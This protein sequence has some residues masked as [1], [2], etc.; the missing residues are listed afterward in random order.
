MLSP[1][2]LAWADILLNLAGAAQTFRLLRRFPNTPGWRVLFVI[3][4][5]MLCAKGLGL[6]EFHAQGAALRLGPQI[7]SI[8]ISAL[9]LLGVWLAGRKEAA[10]EASEI[11]ARRFI[12]RQ[13]SDRYRLLFEAIQE[14]LFVLDDGGRILEVNAVGASLFGLPPEELAG[15]PFSGF[16]AESASWADPF[17]RAA[18]AGTKPVEA[19]VHSVGDGVRVVE[20][21]ARTFEIGE[22][23]AAVLS[24]RDVTQ[25][26]AL[27]SALEEALARERAR[28]MELDA[29]MDAAPAAIW[30]A[31]DPQ[32][33]VI[34][35]NKA[36]QEFLSL[37]PDVNPS[38]TP[39]GPGRDGGPAHFQ[40]YQDGRPLS[41]DEMPMQVA[42]REGQDLRGVEIEIV[43]DDG[44]SRVVEGNVAPLLDDAG[45]SRGAVSVFFD[46][47]KRKEM[48]R[49]LLAAKEAAETA[50]RAKGDFLAR[51]S[52]E[53]RSP[54]A[55]IIGLTEVA[56][57]RLAVAGC[58]PEKT[59]ELLG[60]LDMTYGAGKS[61]ERLIN[62]LLD[63]SRIEAGRLELAETPFEP[64]SAFAAS[65]ALFERMAAAKNMRLSLDVAPEV[66]R[67]I[68][69]D[70]ERLAQIVR[71]LLANAIKHSDAGPV[72]LKASSWM[73]GQGQTFLGVEV[74]DRGPGVPPEK[75]AAI[76]E[77]FTQAS[78]D[79]ARKRQGAGLGLAVSQKLAQLMGGEIHVHDRPGGGS[80]F[81]FHIPVR[82]PASA[83]ATSETTASAAPAP[84]QSRPLRLLVAEDNPL[85]AK[86][87]AHVLTKA[88]YDVTIVGD[89]QQFLEHLDAEED[90]LAADPAGQPFDVLIL[91]V[92]MPVLDGVEAFRTLRFGREVGRWPHL[93]QPP[94]LVLTAYAM[95]GD[96][97]RLLAEGFDGYVSKPIDHEELFRE[98][99]RVVGR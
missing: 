60:M 7:F 48:E 64:A 30:L 68:L 65:L 33:R 24:A 51:M 43:F 77:P 82:L 53:M 26:K 85:L 8:A 78:D 35:G 3:I 47:T 40:L 14:G 19:V 41:G 91:D 21:L 61:L 66:P 93:G 71:N 69:G 57:D 4:L 76:F 20:I 95:S 63:M 94:A 16:M 44:R 15:R 11:E 52:H 74:S 56:L 28:A 54:L 80:V 1:I 96:R 84:Q 55:G 73:D 99:E 42:A 90:R 49:D 37:P 29:I 72:E 83:P 50:N 89:G 31:K 59:R 98:I 46:V 12:A 38:R 97:E 23:R 58:T 17:A 32:C 67:R 87:L 22:R 70:S 81:C 27:E 79:P 75:R 13:A 9:L 62:D 10:Y 18:E 5:I 6:W 2:W 92:Q 39:H 36:A 34:D 25:R 88:G 45:A 86:Y